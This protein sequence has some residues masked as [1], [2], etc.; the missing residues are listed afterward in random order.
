MKYLI[1]CLFGDH[2]WKT[3]GFWRDRP[4]SHPVNGTTGD[5]ELNCEN[6]YA[7]KYSETGIA[8]NLITT[9]IEKDDNGEFS[10]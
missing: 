7:A 8:N 5:Y 2:T 4:H 1:K 6:C 9:L 10:I 3:T